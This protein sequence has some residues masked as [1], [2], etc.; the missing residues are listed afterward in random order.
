MIHSP[1][2]RRQRALSLTHLFVRPGM[3]NEVPS[4]A[5]I[6]FARNGMSPRPS[7]R[8][9]VLCILVGGRKIEGEAM[10]P[11][12]KSGGRNALRMDRS[13]KYHVGSGVAPLPTSFLTT[14]QIAASFKKSLSTLNEMPRE[15]DFKSH[16]M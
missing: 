10:M 7:P 11:D 1:T 2:D 14:L 6:G 15:S 13:I 12:I 16:L 8:V 4:R 5:M 3:R 9:R